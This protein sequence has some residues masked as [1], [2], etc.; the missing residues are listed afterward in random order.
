GEFAY[1]ADWG[2][3]APACLVD[4]AAVARRREVT[5]LASG[6]V[7]HPLDVVRA[8][9]LGARAVGVSGQFLSILDSQGVDALVAALVG[10]VSQ[11]RQLMVVLGAPTVRE[12]AN[13]DVLLTGD[14]AE[15][16]RL[17]GIDPGEYA[18]RAS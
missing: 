4:A 16:C 5:L 3:S 8:L 10:W 11:I 2:Q 1:L 13:T 7:R 12:L 15:F 6:G 14:L 17:R 18:R 9:A